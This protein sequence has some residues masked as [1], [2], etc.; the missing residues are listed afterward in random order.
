MPDYFRRHDQVIYRI[1]SHVATTTTIT[2]VI[3][4]LIVSWFWY[5]KND[6]D[7]TTIDDI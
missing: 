5:Q 4:H 2:T 1:V 7:Y 6:G 3:A